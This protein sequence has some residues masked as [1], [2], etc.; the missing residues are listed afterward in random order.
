MP[1]TFECFYHYARDWLPEVSCR[2][3]EGGGGGGAIP[4][5]L[6]KTVF[7]MASLHFTIKM[8]VIAFKLVLNILKVAAG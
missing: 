4:Y 5:N 7:I 6:V 2:S 8:I 1:Q 3:L